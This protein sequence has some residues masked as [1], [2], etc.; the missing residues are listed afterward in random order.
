MAAVVG[1]P[2]AMQYD[3]GPSASSKFQLENRTGIL[4]STKSRRAV[5]ITFLVENEAAKR[6]KSIASTGE[7]VNHVLRPGSIGI[8]FETIH[9]PA[10]ARR[11][12]ESC[13]P[14]NIA[15]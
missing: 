11:P 2:E 8:R 1:S 10:S 7:T 6:S 4:C 5:N 14:I 3:F 9:N 12:A 13:R 15:L